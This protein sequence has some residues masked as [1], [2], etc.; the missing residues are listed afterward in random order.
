MRSP[1]L[2]HIYLWSG[3]IGK[4]NG[5][6]FWLATWLLHLWCFL[7]FFF[8]S[9]KLNFI[10]YLNRFFTFDYSLWDGGRHTFLR[11]K[12]TLIVHVFEVV[13]FRKFR[14][15]SELLESLSKLLNLHSILVILHVNMWNVSRCNGNILCFHSSHIIYYQ[16]YCSMFLKILYYGICNANC[17]EM[18][19]PWSWSNGRWI[20]NYQC[21]QCLSPLTLWVRNPGQ[22]RCTRYLIMW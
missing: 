12:Q 11:A 5:P 10:C 3:W 17:Y 19:L 1:P 8:Y 18:G 21:I 20:Y 6:R 16:I 7:N 15:K 13:S 2:N 9:L 4:L 22:E 14:W